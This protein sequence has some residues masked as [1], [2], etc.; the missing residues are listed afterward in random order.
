[1][2]SKQWKSKTQ[3]NIHLHYNVMGHHRAVLRV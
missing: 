2:K 1:V 3:N